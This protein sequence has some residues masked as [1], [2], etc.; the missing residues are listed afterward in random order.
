MLSEK[1]YSTN[2]KGQIFTIDLIIGITVLIFILTVSIIFSSNLGIRVNEFETGAEMK[3]IANFATNQLLY[4]PG[5]PADWENLGSLENVSAI[6]LAEE[7][8]LLNLQKVQTFTGSYPSDYNAIKNLLGLSKYDFYLSIERVSD[9]QQLYSFG[10]ATP[11]DAT[12]VYNE[13][14]ALLDGKEVFVKTE[15]YK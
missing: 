15:V 2:S 13:R 9:K 5:D 11:A 14:I 10:I 1:M 6:G 4:S 3:E 7:N 12:V 8:N